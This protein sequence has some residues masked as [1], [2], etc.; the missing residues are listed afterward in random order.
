[1]NLASL[2][3]IKIKYNYTFEIKVNKIYLLNEFLVDHKTQTGQTKF[4]IV[5]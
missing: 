3:K 4:S 5:N 2:K 1:M